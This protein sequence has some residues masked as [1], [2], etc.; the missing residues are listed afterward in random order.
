MLS[1]H[2]HCSTAEQIAEAVRKYSIT[3]FTTVS[4][5]QIKRVK[6]LEGDGTIFVDEKDSMETQVTLYGFAGYISADL[7]QAA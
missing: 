5:K 2:V 3:I 4:A 7:G 6:D 1:F